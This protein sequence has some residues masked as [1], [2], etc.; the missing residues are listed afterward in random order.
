[1]NKTTIISLLLAI[2]LVIIVVP[3]IK[4]TTIKQEEEST[5]KEK[6]ETKEVTSLKT[7]LKNYPAFKDSDVIVNEEQTSVRIDDKYDVTIKNNLY[8]MTIKDHNLESDYCKIVDAIET[9]LGA[10]IGKSTITCEMTLDGT[11]NLGGISVEFFDT[12]KVLTVNADEKAVLYD[13][14]NNQ[15]NKD[16]ISIDKINYGIDFDNYLFTSMSTN[17]LSDSKIFKICGNVAETKKTKDK[18][19]TFTIYD[20]SKNPLDNQTFEYKNDTEKYTPFCLD[21]TRNIDDVRYYSV[22]QK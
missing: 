22:E 8:S 20:E 1:M 19:F 21:Y 9:N 5:L 2:I 11:L 6:V 17:Y 7:A 10:D 12:Y 14:A 16:I 13:T 3:K 18:S 4:S 15:E